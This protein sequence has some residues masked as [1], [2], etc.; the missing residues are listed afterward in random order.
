MEQT[1]AIYETL[2][3]KRVSD[4][5][6]SKTKK[7]MADCQLP[8]DKQ[9]FQV[10]VNLRKVSPRYFTKYHEIKDEITRLGKQLL[11]AVGEGITGQQF[12]DLIVQLGINPNQSTVSR[13]FKAEMLNVVTKVYIFS[14]SSPIKGENVNIS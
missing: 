1:R 10:L 13:W 14:Y 4:T 6:W 11:P 12:L 8:M 7:L 5:H 3:G 9:G 2:V